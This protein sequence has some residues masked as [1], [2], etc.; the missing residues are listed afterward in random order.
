[1]EKANRELKEQLEA[2]QESEQQRLDLVKAI[3]L[4][5][6]KA[7]E[8]QFKLDQ[9]EREGASEASQSPKMNAL[10]GM[11]AKTNQ[12]LKKKIEELRAHIPMQQDPATS[13]I[14]SYFSEV[15]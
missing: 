10:L 12:E 14:A 11:T 15:M 3:G 9:Y 5:R 1:M 8:L 4:E 7:L 6:Q 2:A 13:G